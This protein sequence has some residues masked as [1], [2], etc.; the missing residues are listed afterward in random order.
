MDV[1]AF[2]NEARHL[3]TGR[4][5][6]RSAYHRL[7]RRVAARLYQFVILTPETLDA[8]LRSRPLAL[9]CRLL[10]GVE[11]RGLAQ[12]PAYCETSVVANALRRGAMAFRMEARLKEQADPTKHSPAEFPERFHTSSREGI[13]ARS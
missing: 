11:I 9:D 7:N 8:E 3:G 1:A 13:R 4:A 12:Q 2:V 5:L 10:D 6:L